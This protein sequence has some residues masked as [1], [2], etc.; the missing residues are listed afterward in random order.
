MNKNKKILPILGLAAG[1]AFQFA[2]ICMG[3]AHFRMAG[4]VCISIGAILFSLSVNRLYRLSYEKE[5]P[6]LVRREQI[7][8]ADERNI[9]I[10]SR[11]KSK[12][13]D[14]SRW[15]V[16]GLAWINFLV[17]GSWWITFALVG[18][19]VLV[20]ILEWYYTDKFKKEM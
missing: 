15:A 9:Q 20:Y 12:S 7:E 17:K 8:A 4:G 18:I 5:F 1:L 16:I 10:R 3:A 2:G 14:I 13:S 11:A 19:F 6:L